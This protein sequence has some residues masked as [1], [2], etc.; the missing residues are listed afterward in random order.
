MKEGVIVGTPGEKQQQAK[1][2]GAKMSY[3]CEFLKKKGGGEL[4]SDTVLTIDVLQVL[5]SVRLFA[6]PWTAACQASLSITTPGACSNSC[7]LSQ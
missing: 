6:T 4:T 5:S 2:T 7:P 1:T 3:F